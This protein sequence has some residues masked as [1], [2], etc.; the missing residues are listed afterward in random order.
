[1]S[2]TKKK[3]KTRFV[4]IVSEPIVLPLIQDKV[5]SKQVT[6]N[7]TLEPRGIGAIIAAARMELAPIIPRTIKV[8]DQEGPLERPITRKAVASSEK[9]VISGSK[10]S[11]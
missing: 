11:K 3:E 1:M 9:L 8:T 5:K 10:L 7:P 2:K 4:E 6:E